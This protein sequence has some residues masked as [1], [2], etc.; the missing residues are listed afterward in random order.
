MNEQ[1]AMQD[2]PTEG[3][4]YILWFSASG[5]PPRNALGDISTSGAMGLMEEGSVYF[6]AY[7]KWPDARRPKDLEP[8]QCIRGVEYR[9]SGVGHYDV[10]RVI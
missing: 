5:E 9:L 3:R 7:P 1:P 2:V 6:T 10:Y 4:R 8:G